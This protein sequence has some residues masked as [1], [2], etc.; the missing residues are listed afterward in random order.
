MEHGAVFV[1]FLAQKIA[2]KPF[3]VVGDGNQTRDFT[4]VSDIVNAIYKSL[5]S[6]ISNR[7]INI[8]SGKT[9]SIN[10]LVKL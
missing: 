8:G 5:T 4:Y 6:R 10:Y 7:I 2:N 9:Y 3:T 1:V